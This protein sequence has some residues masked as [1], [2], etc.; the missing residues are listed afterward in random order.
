MRVICAL[1]SYILLRIQ[2]TV[3]CHSLLKSEWRT[4]AKKAIGEDSDVECV[5]TEDMLWL[6]T[7]LPH[8]KLENDITIPA[9]LR[10]ESYTAS[11]AASR[12]LVRRSPISPHAMRLL[13]RQSCQ[14]A[15]LA[16]YELPT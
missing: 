14:T 1:A 15:P 13:R 9:S 5:N 7:R 10:S 2:Q 3:C 12:V 4:L 16:S 8:I 6:G 11:S